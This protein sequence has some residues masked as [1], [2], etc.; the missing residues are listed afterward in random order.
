MRDDSVMK[1]TETEIGEIIDRL[2]EGESEAYT[3]IVDAFHPVVLNIGYRMTGSRE[4]AVDIAQDTFIKVYN[5]ID[6]LEDKAPRIDYDADDRPIAVW[7]SAQT[8]DG[9]ELLHEAME[10]ALAP[11]TL[12]IRC[13]LLPQ[14]GRLRARLYEVG[15]VMAEHSD[16]D[17][18]SIVELRIDRGDWERLTHAEGLGPESWVIRSEPGREQRQSRQQVH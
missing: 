2:D 13:R 16:R 5:K 1:L 6:M 3:G 17:G 4:D 14:A 15:A 9:L 18:A 11:D 7:L 12:D 8:G 10:K